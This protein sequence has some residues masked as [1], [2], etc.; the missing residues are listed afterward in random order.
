MSYAARRR[1]S[2]SIVS[3]LD[4]LFGL[5]GSM[6]VLAIILS[7]LKQEDTPLPQVP[8]VFVEVTLWSD[9]DISRLYL[10]YEIVNAAGARNSIW[11]PLQTPNADARYLSSSAQDTV[12]ANFLMT[13]QRVIDSRNEFLRPLL[14]NIFD[15]EA[16]IR[17]GNAE[18]DDEISVTALIR[19]AHNAC[20]V[21]SVLTVKDL[22]DADQKDGNEGRA[23][24]PFELLA[25]WTGDEGVL[26]PQ[27][28][29][30]P[31][32]LTLKVAN[33]GSVSLDYNT[34]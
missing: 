25:K 15:L 8:F 2:L 16:Q 10:E 4:L 19:T 14:H 12:S 20:P 11:G 28:A 22:L 30:D 26:C 33:E 31:L 32:G 6:I 1:G 3:M 18:M 21:S 23:P 24:S 27:T 13:G 7:F 9:L 5:F 34:N 29:Q 17:Q